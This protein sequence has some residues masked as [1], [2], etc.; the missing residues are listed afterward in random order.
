[1][2]LKKYESKQND[3]SNLNQID[4]FKLPEI[5]F[6]NQ[7]IDISNKSFSNSEKDLI[8]SL[9]Y[10]T[11]NQVT[12]EEL[13]NIIIIV[14]F[15]ALRSMGS[16][17]AAED[18]VLLV[19]DFN[20]ELKN[21][22]KQLTIKEFE[23]I[24]SKG[25]RKRFNTDTIG[26]SIVNFNLWYDAYIIERNNLQIQISNKLHRINSNRQIAPV[27]EVSIETIKDFLISEYKAIK[28]QKNWQ[29]VIYHVSASYLYRQL[30]QL[31]QLQKDSYISYTDKATNNAR[32]NKLISPKDSSEEQKNRII[33]ES[34]RL[35]LVDYLIKQVNK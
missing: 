11:I 16:K 33:W 35:A 24:V 30:V 31:N 9:N 8:Q 6:S 13:E 29:K 5:K 18:R 10:K 14:V 2:S 28:S 3:I 19:N 32:D 15:N 25:I 22:F 26:I 1:M 21:Y 12:H 20:W 34:K 7:L 27:K 4:D 23:I 17:M